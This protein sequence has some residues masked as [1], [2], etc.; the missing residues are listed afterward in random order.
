MLLLKNFVNNK[1][2]VSKRFITIMTSPLADW[3][4]YSKKLKYIPYSEMS[5]Y[6]NIDQ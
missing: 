1:M 4:L 3:G 2:S 5:F 6:S